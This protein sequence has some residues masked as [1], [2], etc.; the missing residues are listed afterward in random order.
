MLRGFTGLFAAYR[1]SVYTQR[2]T[3]S[4]AFKPGIY[5]FL[6]TMASQTVNTT[7]RLDALRQLMAKPENDVTAYVIPSEDQR[8]CPCSRNDTVRSLMPFNQDSSE[9]IAHCDRRRAYISGF[10]GSAGMSFFLVRTQ[11]SCHLAFLFVD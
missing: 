9:Y 10:T 7:K 3:A 5:C 2:S 4:R 6:S 1:I 11:R 8:Q